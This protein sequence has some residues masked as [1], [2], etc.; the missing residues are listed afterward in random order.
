MLGLGDIVLPG[1]LLSFAARFDAAKSLLGILGGGNGTL[2][3][4][5]CPERKLCGNCNLCSGGYFLPLV[6]AYGVGLFMANAGTFG[7]FSKWLPC[8]TL[9]WW[10][11][12]D[13][14]PFF[15]RCI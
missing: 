10:N 6:I 7:Q 13:I 4:P 1:L 2:N 15:Q 5:N 14:P 11:A 3:S 9:S 8:D 12:K